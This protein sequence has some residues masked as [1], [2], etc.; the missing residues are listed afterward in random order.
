M[1]GRRQ[2]S[3][4]L[5]TA[6]LATLLGVVSV[7]LVTLPPDQP[8]LAGVPY[9]PA[10]AM[11]A[12][13]AAM[14][15]LAELGLI[16][17]EFRRQ[18][19]SFSLSGIPL[20][21]GLL[22][23]TP[24]D[25]LI[26]R[27]LGAVLAFAVQRPVL[28]KAGYNL[29]AYLFE[30]AAVTAAAHLLLPGDV[31]LQLATATICY[32]V[33]VAADVMMSLLV[34]VVIAL[35]QGTVTRAEI[36]GVVLPAAVFS[37][38][39]TAFAF[40]AALLIDHGTLGTVLVLTC[41][42][43]TAGVYRNYLVLRRRHQALALVHDFVADGVGVETTDELAGRLLARVRQLLRAESAEIV[44]TDDDGTLRLGV[45]E[46]GVHPLPAGSPVSD[47]LLS[48][49]HEQEE[50]VLVPRTT[51][52]RGLRRW[53]DSRGVRDALLVPLSAPGVRGV[54]L[55][56]DRLGDTTTFT[57]DDLTLLQTLAGHLSVALR[58][59]RVVAQLR[60]E[61]HHDVLTGLPNRAL[62][63]ERLQAALDTRGA[64][65]PALLLLDLDRFKEVN[66]TLGHHVGDELLKVV[67]ERIS[68]VVPADA[69]VARLG[70]D[71]FAV[72]LPARSEPGAAAHAVAQALLATLSESVPLPE[73]VVSTRASIGV[74]IGEARLSGSDLLRHAD[75]AMYVAK[76]TVQHIVTY[77]SELDRGRAERLALLADLGLALERDELELRYQPQLDLA[78]GRIG[79]VEALVRWRHPR[80]GLL[81][82][83]AFIPLAESTG[84]IDSLTRL[85]LR[86][87][88]AD[89]RQ[90]RAHGLDLT[91]AVN[92]SA[93][94]VN[95]VLLP[96]EVGAALAEAG[97]PADRLVLEIT[98]S[99]V[100]GDPDRTVP[101][102]TRLAD[103]GVVLSL[104]DFGTGYS[105]LAYLQRLPVHEVKIDRSFVSGLAA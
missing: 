62:L 64:E 38:A 86:R 58:G 100:M 45:G 80:L 40:I 82:A 42:A 98:E 34:L 31:E 67:A 49:L 103:M 83:D 30:T 66:D 3:P 93:R 19:W 96:E 48:R 41:A 89:C 5:A 1:R 72:L 24:S 52:D 97:L 92:L 85:V 65:R 75:T 74:A 21:L 29:G 2:R 15:M 71:E 59:A 78:T 8:L 11:V 81:G 104:D 101:T 102:L 17:V 50:P 51:R 99:A 39:G 4:S 18:A 57:T 84:L 61:A 33:V 69:T 87:A 37:A 88:L 32:L 95:N 28:L 94:N 79:G 14:F 22:T 73:A 43:G 47:W 16:H 13:F 44:L 10:T 26:A 91:V 27:V 6:A 54:V 70:G 7:G 12:G 25:L 77:T 35:H 23:C 53:L 36:A 63:R 105:S 55:V 90:W 56:T 60:H 76:D 68:R 9:V 46:D 20:V